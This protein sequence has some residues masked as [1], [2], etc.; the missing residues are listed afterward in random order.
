MPYPLSNTEIKDE[1]ARVHDDRSGIMIASSVTCIVAAIIAV[2]LRLL[3][4]RLGKA[5]ILADD[6]LIITAFVS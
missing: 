5:K 6:Y 1:L 3:T 4:R 2:I